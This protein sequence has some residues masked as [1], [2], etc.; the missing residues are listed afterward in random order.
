[1]N[2]E[3]N[4]EQI[5][6]ILE[7]QISERVKTWFAQQ[8]NKYIIRDYVHQAVISELRNY[9]YEIIAREEARKQISHDMVD[10]I[11]AR[12]SNDIADAFAEK[13]GDY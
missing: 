10:K 1:M 2:I 6:K 9:K 11:C 8:E 12:V 4:D 5:Q 13:Y 7:K 3:I